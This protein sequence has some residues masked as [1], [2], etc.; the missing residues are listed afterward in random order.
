MFTQFYLAII[1]SVLCSS[2]TVW[3]ATKSDI[4]T[5]DDLDCWKDYWC[6]PAHPSRTG[7]IQSEEKGK[8]LWIPHI[9]AIS[10]LNLC[11]L[12][13]TTG[14]RTPGQPGTRKVSSPRQSWTIKCSPHFAIKICAIPLICIWD[15]YFS[16]L[17]GL[18]GVGAGIL[19]IAPDHLFCWHQPTPDPEPSQESPRCAKLQPEPVAIDE[20]LP[21]GA[22]ELR[23][24][25]EPEPE[26]QPTSDQVHETATKP[27]CGACHSGAW[28]HGEKPRPLQHCWRWTQRN[29]MNYIWTC[30][31]FSRLLLNCQSALN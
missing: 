24:P 3:F 9:Q 4:R 10:F 18:R 23:I 19:W 6:S 30:P 22:T 5:M 16:L 25:P 29:L 27:Q 7:Y 17:Q 2:I 13:G 14:H 15:I 26:P 31:F 11:Q 1:E 20:P 12:V 28:G 21:R 8:S